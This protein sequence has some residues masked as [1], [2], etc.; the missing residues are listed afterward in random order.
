MIYL[1]DGHNLIGKMPDIQLSDP[2]D[3]EKLVTRLQSWTRLDRKRKIQVVFDAGQH[4]GFGDL[5]S[6]LNVQV[7]FSRMGQTAD[8]ILIRQIKDIRNPQTHAHHR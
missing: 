7:R 6:G 2:D 8:S 4:G 1:I 5:L 3:E